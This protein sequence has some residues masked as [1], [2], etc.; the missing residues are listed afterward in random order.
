MIRLFFATIVTLV[1]GSRSKRGLI[2]D[3]E[4]RFPSATSTLLQK[5]KQRIRLGDRVF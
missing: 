3:R 2:H 4:P 5:N 1:S